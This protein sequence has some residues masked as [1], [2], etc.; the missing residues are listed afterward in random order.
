LNFIVTPYAAILKHIRSCESNQVRL[1]RVYFYWMCN[2][3]SCYEWFAEMLQQLERDLRD[4]G[5]L[6]TYNIYLTQWSMGQARAVIKNN[7]D[8]RDI[9][10]GLESKTYYGRPNFEVDF[11]SIINEDWGMRE[12]RHI[13]VFVCGPKPL[14]KQLQCLCIK[15]NDHSSST[16]NVC[17]YLNKENF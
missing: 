6:L 12:K 15:I 9:W 11:Q 13:G 14:V 7:T 8:E 2:T 5:N 10:T 17:F 4:R 3:T 1:R 16:N